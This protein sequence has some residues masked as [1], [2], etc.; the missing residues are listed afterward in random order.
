ML[1]AFEDMYSNIVPFRNLVIVE[2]FNDINILCRSD[3]KN[4]KLEFKNP[5]IRN[6]QLTNFKKWLTVPSNSI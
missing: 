2:P 4:I 5:E 6:Q 3:N 1:A